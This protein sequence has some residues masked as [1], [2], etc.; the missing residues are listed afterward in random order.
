MAARGAIPPRQA[1]KTNPNAIRRT[2]VARIVRRA[3]V[4]LA[5]AALLAMPQS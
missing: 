5:K 2:I 3:P 1:A 4:Q